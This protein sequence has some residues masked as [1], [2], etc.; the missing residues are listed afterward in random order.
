MKHHSP[1][2]DSTL[3]SVLGNQL[4]E[5][6]AS[7][8]CSAFSLGEE[9][10][11]TVCFKMKSEEEISS[12]SEGASSSVCSGFFFQ[13]PYMEKIPYESNLHYFFQKHTVAM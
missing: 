6:R 2:I 3:A 9:A 1:F 12:V 7:V 5:T 8:L 4:E 10:G 11:R 13:I